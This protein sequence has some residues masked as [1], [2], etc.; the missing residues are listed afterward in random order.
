MATESRVVLDG[1]GVARALRRIAGEIAERHGGARDVALVGIRRGGVP[2]AERLAVLVAETEGVK[3]P[4]GAVDITLYRD[5]ASTALPKPVIGPT[6]LSFPVDRRVVIL[7]D[8]VLFTGRTVRAAVDV[9]LDFG[10][11]RAIELV[12]LVDRGGRELPIRADYVGKTVEAAPD[13][14]VEVALSADGAG[15]VTIGRVT[16]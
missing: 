16:R 9:V 14:H 8:D 13:E 15:V 11:P 7:V 6:D 12:A 10:R 3:P 1:D 5:D 2:L 4:V